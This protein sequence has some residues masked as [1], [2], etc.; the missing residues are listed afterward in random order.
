MKERKWEDRINNLEKRI[1]EWIDW[2]NGKM[3]QFGDCRE[4]NGTRMEEDTRSKSSNEEG[5]SEISR[6]RYTFS[7]RGSSY[8]VSRVSEDRFSEKEVKFIKNG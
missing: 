6:N 2:I 1:K 4:R 8:E 7:R 3:E 5:R